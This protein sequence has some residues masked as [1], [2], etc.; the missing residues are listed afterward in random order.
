MADAFA[1]GNPCRAPAGLMFDA[2]GLRRFVRCRGAGLV[3]GVEPGRGPQ[4]LPRV[5]QVAACLGVFSA[6]VVGAGQ[7]ALACGVGHAAG[8]GAGRR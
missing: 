3:C 1:A 7:P 2:L 5:R 4:H 6:V 8:V